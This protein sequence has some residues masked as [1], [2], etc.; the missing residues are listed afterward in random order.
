MKHG[1]LLY[2]R[3]NCGL[4]RPKLINLSGQG[5]SQIH[6]EVHPQVH[7][8]FDFGNAGNYRFNHLRQAVSIGSASTNWLQLTVSYDGSTIRTYRDGELV[9][10]SPQSLGQTT[11]RSYQLGSNRA[12]NFLFAGC[13]DEV[14]IWN[15]VRTQ[16]DIQA[17]KN[18]RLKG[19]ESGL[20]TYYR[21]DEGSG[22]ELKDQTGN[23]RDAQVQG[24]TIWVPTDEAIGYVPID[25]T[26]V[27]EPVATTVKEPDPV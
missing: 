10:E 18:Q 7:F 20:V 5:C 13:I 15:T 27:S 9:I 24:N 3:L 16:S 17:Y 11:F 6:L 25:P 4:N 2:S 22:S 8:S 12:G 14:R 19:N 26:S 1:Q 21:F 23:G